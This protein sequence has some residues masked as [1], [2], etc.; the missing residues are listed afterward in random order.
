MGLSF[1][2]TEV[3]RLSGSEALVTQRFLRIAAEESDAT[4]EKG[5][6]VLQGSGAKSQ[7]CATAPRGSFRIAPFGANTSQSDPLTRNCW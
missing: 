5:K 7:G 3:P 2:M 1:C 4:G 6:T